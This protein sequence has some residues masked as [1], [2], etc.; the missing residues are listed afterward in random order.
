MLCSSKKCKVK[1][2]EVYLEPSRT[3]MTEFLCK[4]SE[5]LIVLNYFCKKWSIA[6]VRLSSKYAGLLLLLLLLLLGAPYK[7]MPLNSFLLTCL[8]QNLFLFRFQK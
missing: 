8:R 2:P 7:M 4:K 6:D 5:R 1:L 3:S